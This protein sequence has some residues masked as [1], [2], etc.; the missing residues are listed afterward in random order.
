[1]LTVQVNARGDFSFYTLRIV[2]SPHE[3]SDADGFD[4]QLA[5]LEFSFKAG[6]P[7]EFDCQQVRE[8]PPEKR[9]EPEIDYLAKDY[10]SFRRLMLDRMSAITPDWRER[11][12]A[13]AQIALVE[14][15]AY[16][17]D[18]LSYYQDAVA[19]EAYLG[20]ARKRVSVRRHARLARLLHARR[21]QRAHLAVPGSRRRQRPGEARRSVRDEG[22]NFRQRSG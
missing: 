15:L 16:V 6:C 17:G 20:T 12:P 4:P 3:Q 9:V 1:M 7:S 19:T 14:L 13:D 22:K 5:A 10:A 11:N 21:G 2:N 18:H 8:C